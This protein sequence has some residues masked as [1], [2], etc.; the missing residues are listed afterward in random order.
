M[1][2][3]VLLF[4]RTTG[5]RHDS[6]PAAAA[7]VRELGRAAGF[8]VD[9]T[10]DPAAFSADGLAGYGAVVFASTSGTVFDDDAQRA[11]LAAFTARGGGFA[12]VHAA[13]TTEPDRP[14][15]AD[16]LGARFA[17]HPAPCRATLRVA[18]RRHP[19]T[20]HLGPTWT[21]TDEWYVFDAP[22]RPGSRV[23]LTLADTATATAT[24]T[25]G[26]GPGAG[27]RGGAGTARPIAWCREIGPA[28]SFYTALG[29]FADAYADPRFRAHLLGGIRYALGAPD[30]AR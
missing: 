28:R 8:G 19:A 14:F 27:G 3:R 30:A 2:D 21:R 4:T 12:G 5:Y 26:A 23:L 25:D 6:I 17:G 1:A 20:A 15:F 11:A 18:D 7:A 10:E 29:H 22:P 13:A 24:A 16:L 9:A